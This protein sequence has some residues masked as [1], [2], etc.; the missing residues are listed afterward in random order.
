[1]RDEGVDRNKLNELFGLAEQRIEESRYDEALGLARQI[2]S[3][4]P[5][6]YVS[7]ILSGL[8]INIGSGFNRMEIMEEGR[9]LLQKDF[10]A[11]SEHIE[12]AP[13]ANYNLANANLFI[14][15]LEMTK[16][17]L[18]VLFSETKLDSAKFHYQKAFDLRTERPKV[19]ST[20]LC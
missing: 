2:Q 5:H 3:V 8:L 7:Y 20:N 1:M 14:F 6:Y 10:G 19:S 13:T 11:I 15:E 12:L 17:P 9:Q 16:N 18:L 4:G